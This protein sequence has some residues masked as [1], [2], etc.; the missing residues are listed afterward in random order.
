MRWLAIILL[1][2]ILAVPASL[3]TKAVPTQ[4]TGRVNIDAFGAIGDAASHQLSSRYGTVAAAQAVYPFID[5]LTPQIDEVA[6]QAAID[7]CANNWSAFSGQPGGCREITCPAGGYVTSMPLFLD[8]PHNLRG[9]AA[10]WVAGTTYAAGNVVTWN[11]VPWVSQSSGNVGNTPSAA[12]AF[13]DPTTQGA[14]STS[15]GP[16]FI[17]DEGLPG[18]SPLAGCV[19]M[20]N[21]QSGSIV[22]YPVLWVGPANGALVKNVSIKGPNVGYNCQMDGNGVAFAFPGKGSRS[23]LENIGV[24]H[25]Y[26]GVKYGADGVDQVNDSNTIEKANIGPTCIGVNWTITQSYLNDIINSNICGQFPIFAPKGTG[27]LINGGNFN[28]CN[29]SSATATL[30][31][32]ST[33]MNQSG[34]SSI[35]ATVTLTTGDGILNGAACTVANP[36]GCVY[37]AW[38]VNTTHYGI[39]P[40]TLTSY[41]SATKVAV[42]QLRGGWIA[43]FQ[44]TFTGGTSADFMTEVQNATTWYAV[45]M[46]T[47]F[48]GCGISVNDVHVESNVV[49]LELFKSNCI[50][51]GAR[52]N[53]IHNMYFNYDVSDFAIS[54]TAANFPAW[55]AQQ[56]HPFIELGNT[57]LIVDWVNFEPAGNRVMVEWVGN[58]ED[59]AGSLIWRGKTIPLNSLLQ[60]TGAGAGS[61]T[62]GNNANGIMSTALQVGQFDGTFGG[63]AYNPSANSAAD[64]WRTIGLGK[65]PFWGVRPAPYTEPCLSAGQISTFFPAGVVSG[66]PAIGSYPILWGGQVYKL[67]DWNAAGAHTKLVSNHLF[68][69]YG[70]NITGVTWSLH[71]NSPVMYVSDTSLLFNGLGV[72]LTCNGFD[73]FFIINGVYP[74]LGYVTLLAGDDTGNNIVPNYGV[75]DCTGQTVI[76][77]GSYNITKF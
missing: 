45:E 57:D 67:C 51:G 65:T 62:R 10:K 12:S 1:G 35:T 34:G 40:F 48:T 41:N 76:K 71:Q 42:L 58:S 19:L 53:M 63:G 59:N 28:A 55:Y 46:V 66:L 75:A 21:G 73:Q 16:T 32:T 36:T 68:W 8:L 22:N 43:R 60:N 15:W 77:Q 37:N 50:F 64:K 11:G 13:W 25:V 56:T 14:T 5:D 26:N 70:Q 9:N 31:R 20:P 3:P 39:V 38:T 17:G 6:I 69:S 4:L 30:A 47:M 72:L 27:V 44:N 33:V 7:Y 29:E 24:D 52:P 49:A 18:G 2:L 23:K 74:T 54:G 61:I